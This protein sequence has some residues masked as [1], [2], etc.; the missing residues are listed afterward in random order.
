[1]APSMFSYAARLDAPG[2]CAIA[3]SRSDSASR[4]LPPLPRKE[5][6]RFGLGRDLLFFHNVSRCLDDR[7]RRHLLQVELQ[8][9]RQ[10]P[11]QEFLRIR[12]ASTN[13][14]ARRLSSVFSMALKAWAGELVH[15]SMT[16]TL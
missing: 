16:Y 12:V 15:S 5:P 8:T 14:C 4:M 1:M 13:F 11:S 3:W 10:P 9:A 2:L 7:R 6:Q